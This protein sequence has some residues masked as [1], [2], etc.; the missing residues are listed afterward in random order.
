MATRLGVTAAKRL[1]LA[2]ETFD[3]AALRG[4]GFVDWWVDDA[5]SLPAAVHERAAEMASFAP[6]SVQGMKRAL[7]DIA[8]GQFDEAAVAKQAAQCWASEDLQEGLAARAEGRK[9]VF[10]GK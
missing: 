6:L 7:N 5:A 1:L 9:P 3:E 10:K 4:C 8:N 2:G